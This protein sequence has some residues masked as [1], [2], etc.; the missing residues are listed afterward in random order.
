MPK[1]MTCTLITIFADYG[2]LNHNGYIIYANL[3]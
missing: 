2:K 3:S 1:K